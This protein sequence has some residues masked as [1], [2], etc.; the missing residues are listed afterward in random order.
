MY[1]YNISNVYT[2]IP[3]ELR[4]EAI[5]YWLHKK[6]SLIPQRFRNDFII[7]SLNIVLKK[8]QCFI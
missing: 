7:E 1:S 6:R 2:L 8:R 4:I 3:T 5:R